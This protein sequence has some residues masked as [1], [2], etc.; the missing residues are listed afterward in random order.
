MTTSRLKKFDNGHWVF[1]EQL[2]F[3]N[4]YGFVYLI[5][6][7]P[8]NMAYIG[9]KN[10]QSHGKATKGRQSNWREYVGSS[11]LLVSEYEK[12]GYDQF[13][14]IVLEQYKFNGSVIWAETWS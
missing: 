12:Y 5:K 14:F 1:P 13:E 6:C 2:D 10:F 9:K 8:T 11:T 7:I 3:K 4:M